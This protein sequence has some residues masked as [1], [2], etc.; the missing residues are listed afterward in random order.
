M[1][2]L[3]NRLIDGI[4]VMKALKAMGREGPF[5]E[6]VLG[7]V[8]RL[9]DLQRRSIISNE[10]MRLIPE[11]M[12]AI[13]IA[14]GMAVLL[15]YWQAGAESLLTVLYLFFRLHQGVSDL[16]MTLRDITTGQPAFYFVMSLRDATRDFEERARGNLRAGRWKELSLENVSFSHDDELILSNANLTIQRGEFV[17]FFGPSGAAKR[18][19]LIC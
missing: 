15:P 17:T 19:R 16:P 7:D 5:R 11:P 14:V 18:Q 9:Y 8:D 10:F 13:S 4:G 2:L 1:R 6:N 12:G 3:N